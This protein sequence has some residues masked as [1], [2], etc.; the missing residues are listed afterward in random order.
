RG[1]ALV[2]CGQWVYAKEQSSWAF[3]NDLPNSDCCAGDW[4]KYL[5]PA[6]SSTRKRS[7]YIRL[8]ANHAHQPIAIGTWQNLGRS[9]T[10]VFRDV[11][12]DARGFV[13]SKWR[14]R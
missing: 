10:D 5:L 11:V 8:S 4:R 14:R 3:H 1:I 13:G 6:I 9:G 7:E 2:C 12:F